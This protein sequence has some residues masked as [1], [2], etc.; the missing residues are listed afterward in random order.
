[1][2]T[3]A[4]APAASSSNAALFPTMLPLIKPRDLVLIQFGHNDKE[5]T[6][7]DYRANLTSM[8]SQVRGRGGVPVLVTPPVRRWFTGT[9]LNATG[10]HINGLGVDLPAEMRAVG[11]ARNV[12]VIDLT[13]K[14]EAL[15]EALGPADSAAIYLRADVDGVRDNTH[16]SEYGAGVMAELVLQGA[17]ELSLPLVAFLR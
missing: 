14:S 9:Q 2:P 16:F 13:A 6:A 11:A 15:V 10:L 8:I 12:P 7:A 3:P 1:M 4:R 5:T 17:R